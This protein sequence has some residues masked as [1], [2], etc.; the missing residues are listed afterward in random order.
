ML[1]LRLRTRVQ[2]LQKQALEIR[3][4]QVPEQEYRQMK[5]VWRVLERAHRRTRKAL[6]VRGLHQMQVLER[7][8]QMV[9]VL[10]P[11]SHQTLGQGCQ[12]RLE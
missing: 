6:Q 4:R 3:S 2:V 7:G 12:T 11:R 9:P 5:T 1:V 8:H 10:E